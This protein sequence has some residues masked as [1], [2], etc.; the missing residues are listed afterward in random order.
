LIVVKLYT[1]PVG[2]VCETAPYNS[3]AGNRGRGP[4]ADADRRLA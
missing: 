3:V 4:W 2:V 1:A